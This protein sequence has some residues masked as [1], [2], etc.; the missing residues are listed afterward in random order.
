MTEQAISPLRRRMIKGLTIRTT[1][2]NPCKPTTTLNVTR[3][4]GQMRRSSRV[5]V[6]T[7]A[8]SVAGGH[9]RER[10]RGCVRGYPSANSRSMPTPPH[11]RRSWL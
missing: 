7:P 6:K 11:R 9:H 8:L 3:C 5:R 2:P 10:N 4:S 1:V